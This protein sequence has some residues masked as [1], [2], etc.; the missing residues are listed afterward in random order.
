M[1]AEDDDNAQLLSVV[2]TS[3]TA[4]TSASLHGLHGETALH[5]SAAIGSTKVIEILVERKANPNQQ[6]YDGETPLHYAAL[7]GQR[8][9]V[10]LLLSKGAVPTMTS[11]F[12]ETA[13]ELARENPA[14]FLGTN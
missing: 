9:A 3:K 6:D 12:M 8:H 10:S 14:A 7:A 2:G 1:G 13:S 11:Y 4:L 5:I